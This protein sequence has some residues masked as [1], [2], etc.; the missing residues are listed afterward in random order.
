MG[1]HNTNSSK[2]G[3]AHDERYYTEGEINSL[4]DNRMVSYGN[5][6]SGSLMNLLQ[7]ATVSGTAM[8]IGVYYPPDVPIKVEFQCLI[9]VSDGRKT[10]I[11]FSYNSE[12]YVY[13]RSVYNGNWLT[14]WIR[15]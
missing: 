3:H 9:L 12:A 5:I 10:I 4:L 8:I 6:T 7:R 11:L 13:K 2:V 15:L 14:D 1:G